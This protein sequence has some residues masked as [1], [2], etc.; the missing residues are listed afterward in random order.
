MKKCIAGS[1]LT[2]WLS[3]CLI[4]VAFSS[5]RSN[6]DLTFLLDSQNNRTVNNPPPNDEYRVQLNDNLY[7]SVISPN[8]DMNELYNPAVVGNN[9]N[10]NNVWQNLEG[11]LVQGYLVEPD[12]TITLPAI[13]KIAFRTGLWVIGGPAP[14]CRALSCPASLA[15]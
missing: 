7:V 15:R 11:Q 9:R 8:T 13:G 10:I 14:H 5:C 4:V 12:G 1:G 3:F 6:K 2:Q